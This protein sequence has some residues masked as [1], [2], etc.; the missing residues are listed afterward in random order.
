MA[1]LNEYVSNMNNPLI[2]TFLEN[3]HIEM[4]EEASMAWIN[5]H[6]NDYSFSMIHRATNRFIGNCSLGDFEENSGTIGLYLIPEFQHLGIGTEVIRELI[7][8]GFEELNLDE[9]RLIVFSNNNLAIRCYENIGFR[10]Y[11]R[12]TAV[13]TR[14]NEPV[15]DIYMSLTR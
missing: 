14:N 3:E 9:I 5:R 2:N 15:D 1:Y 13:T 10:E 4:T 11:N 12:I 8:I 7:R 6:Q